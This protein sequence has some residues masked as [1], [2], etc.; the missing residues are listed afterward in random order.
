MKKQLI[1]LLLIPV[2]AFSNTVIGD[3]TLVSSYDLPQ[4]NK[5]T[6]TLDY[7]FNPMYEENTGKV[8]QC[9][10][11]KMV[12]G[13]RKYFYWAFHTLGPGTSF[14]VTSMSGW[15]AGD[16][17]MIA[18]GTTYSSLCRFENMNNIAVFN[19]TTSGGTLVK[20]TAHWNIDGDSACTFFG[21]GVNSRGSTIFKVA[22]TN[23]G[24]LMKTNG[25][26]FPANNRNVYFSGFEFDT[27]GRCF[28]WSENQLTQIYTGNPPT[29]LIVGIGMWNMVLVDCAELIYGSQG[30]AQQYHNVCDSVLV[31]DI[32]CDTTSSG[33]MILSAGFYRMNVYRITVITPEI[34]HGDVAIVDCVGGGDGQVHDSYKTGGNQFV[35]WHGGSLGAPGSMKMYNIIDINT[36]EY[37]ILQ[38]DCGAATTDSV[39]TWPDDIYIINITGGDRRDSVFTNLYH[40]GICY[41]GQMAAGRHLYIQNNLGFNFSNIDANGLGIA[42]DPSAS[43]ATQ[44]VNHN[45]YYTSATLAGIT[46]SINCYLNPGSPA[47]GVGTSTFNGLDITGI[48]RPAS[49]SLGAREL[50]CPNCGYYRRIRPKP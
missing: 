2:F 50:T 49:S 31:H 45:A 43:P 26:Q 46:D 18:A 16:Q 25:I 21:T 10:G 3:R 30:T 42:I 37:P 39:L 17:A 36:N 23:I 13:K 33:E 20:F 32:I 6:N 19:D 5:N 27:V 28:D 24:F 14:S 38:P 7:S 1:I 35:R 41:V 29:K 8:T 40:C 9:Y 44:V 15:S 22:S 48:I 12:D 47:I 34:Y 11:Y 4:W